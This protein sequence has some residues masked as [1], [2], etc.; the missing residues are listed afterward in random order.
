MEELELSVMMLDVDPTDDLRPL[1]D[2]FE[3]QHKCRVRV[4]ALPWQ[5][6]GAI[7]SRRPCTA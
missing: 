4:S 5:P 1:L 3:A 7:W 6:A 2:Q